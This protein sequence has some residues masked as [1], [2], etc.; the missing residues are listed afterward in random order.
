[1]Y[2]ARAGG[3]SVTIPLWS[4]FALL[5]AVCVVYPL[6][7]WTRKVD[8]VF[9]TAWAAFLLFCLAVWAGVAVFVWWWIW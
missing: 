1:M 7:A 6:P 4:P 2:R 3:R 5:A 8:W 9:V